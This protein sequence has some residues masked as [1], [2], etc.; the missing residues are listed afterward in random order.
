MD[1]VPKATHEVIFTAHQRSGDLDSDDEADPVTDRP[2]FE[3]YVTDLHQ[4]GR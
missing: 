1:S 4:S 3:A 2:D